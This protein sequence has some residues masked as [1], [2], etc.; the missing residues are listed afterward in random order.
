M[1]KATR[2]NFSPIF[3]M[4]PDPERRFTHEMAEA[5][6]TP[7]GLHYADD[8]HTQHRLWRVTDEARI[9]TFIQLARRR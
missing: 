6:S 1:L 5:M 7:A 8:G 9:A 2:A 4:F 3:L